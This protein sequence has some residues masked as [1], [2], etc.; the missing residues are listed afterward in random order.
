MFQSNLILFDEIP[1]TRC[2]SKK[3]ILWCIDD[4]FKW[5]ENLFHEGFVSTGR[6]GAAANSSKISNNSTSYT[7]VAPGGIFTI[8]RDPELGHMSL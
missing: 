3:Y 8:L 7:N 1:N 2:G 6:C 5:L 4:P